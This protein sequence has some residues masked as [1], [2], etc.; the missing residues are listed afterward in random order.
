MSLTQCLDG[1]DQQFICMSERLDIDP[2][3]NSLSGNSNFEDGIQVVDNLEIHPAA[4]DL[5]TETS[6]SSSATPSDDSYITDIGLLMDGHLLNVDLE[7]GIPLPPPNIPAGALIPIPVEP[8]ITIA[9][10]ILPDDAPLCPICCTQRP[11]DGMVM[12][13]CCSESFCAQCLASDIQAQ[14]EEGRAIIPCLFCEENL[15]ESLVFQH[16]GGIDKKKFTYRLVNAKGKANLKACSQC[17]HVVERTERDVKKMKRSKSKKSSLVSRTTCT[18]CETNFCFYCVAPCHEG[19]SCASFQKGDGLFKDWMKKRNGN[20]ANAHKCPKCKVPIQRI[21]GCSNM[22]CSKCKTHWCYDCGKTKIHTIIF[23]GHES[24]WSIF[25]CDRYK[26]SQGIAY[27]KM[28]R[29]GVFVGE[30]CILSAA[31]LLLAPILLALGPG[32]IVFGVPTL[33][34]GILFYKRIS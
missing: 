32:L 10:D 7:T 4:Y 13:P 9:E 18:N 2:C 11:F 29:R 26:Y 22:T 6:Y 14:Y 23:G 28:V 5:S 21:S 8:E 33:I 34:G 30:L 20:Q 16:L 24:K 25:G 12:L 1:I 27:T 17:F 19:V 31:A 15:D 3:T